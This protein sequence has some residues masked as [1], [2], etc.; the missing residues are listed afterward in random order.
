MRVSRE[1]AEKN[2]MKVVEVASRMFRGRGFDG[3]GIADIMSEAGLTH[4]GFYGQFGSKQQLAAEA[5]RAAMARTLRRWQVVLAD[6]AGAPMRAVAAFYLTRAHR[7]NPETGCAFA[8]LA[9]DAARAGP[10]VKAVFEAG[11]ADQADLI[12]AALMAQ[13]V[14]KSAARAQA[15]A[16][17]ATLVGALALSRAVNDADLSTE[18]LAAAHKRVASVSDG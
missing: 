7:D 6:A 16:S 3:A 1:Q 13:G 18:I 5:S 4:G 8:A 12:Q 9:S 2:R 17:L 11:L 10:E 15:L 14:K